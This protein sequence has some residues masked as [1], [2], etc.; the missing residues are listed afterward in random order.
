MNPSVGKLTGKFGFKMFGFTTWLL[1][2]VHNVT[3]LVISSDELEKMVKNTIDAGNWFWDSKFYYV[4]IGTWKRI[5]STDLTDIVKWESNRRDCDNISAIFKSHV[6]EYF[7]LNGVGIVIGE[8]KDAKTGK[9]IG[10]HA[11]NV[12]IAEELYFLEPQ[13]DGI[14]KAKEGA[15]IGNWSYYPDFIMWY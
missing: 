12:L 7:G 1:R 3:E 13:N 4:K 15:V 2:R 9:H 10:Y 11:W 5:I 8:V 6:S 14:V